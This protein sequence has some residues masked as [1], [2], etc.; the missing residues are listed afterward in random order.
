[1]S[2]RI[3]QS[4]RSGEES[5][6]SVSDLMAGL[7]MVFL[8]IAVVY[9]R[10]V[11]KSDARTHGIEWQNT[12]Q[13]IS[14]AL[15][16]EFSQ[17]ELRKWG[18][19]IIDENLTIRFTAPEVLFADGKDEIPRRFKKIL[20]EFMP[21]YIDLLANNFADDIDEVRIE[22]HTSSKFLAARDD[23][24]AFIRNME[25]SQDRTLAVLEYSF[26]L[27]KLQKHDKWMRDKVSANG[28]SSARIRTFADG[29]EDEDRS[30]RVEF[31]IKTKTR[32]AL[33][34]VIATNEAG[35]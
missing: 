25:L 9:A 21:R 27:S 13:A 6:I 1:M 15:H 16:E 34:K 8:F 22:G 30:R 11:Q 18:A 4:K 7:M 10:D 26:G 12:E 23:N 24:D 20:D 33:Q 31:T 29:K 5:W 19:E 28:L 17:R 14:D 3:F 32:E 35:Q 2:K